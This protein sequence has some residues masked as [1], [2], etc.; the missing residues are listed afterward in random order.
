MNDLHALCLLPLLAFSAAAVA[1]QPAKPTTAIPQKLTAQ[2]QSVLE[3]QDT[4][5]SEA[6]A[7]IIQ[8]VEQGKAGEVWDGASI[9]A[10]TSTTR[11][12]FIK[13]IDDDRKQLGA[14]SARRQQSVARLNYSSGNNS[15]EG[16][17]I[18][19]IYTT[20]FAN[21]PQPIRELVSFRLDPDKVWRMSGY[22]VR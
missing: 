16:Y 8:L 22:S 17:Y 20:R 9:A 18:S 10:K 12:S 11:D 21:T 3:R 19:V 15:T 6:A 5:F 14:V 13:N 2:Q 7:T 1:E 4:A